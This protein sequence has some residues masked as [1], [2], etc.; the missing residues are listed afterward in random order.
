MCGKRNASN[1]H[2]TSP[3]TATSEDSPTG[4]AASEVEIV[5]AARDEVARRTRVAKRIVV[6]D[7]RG[8]KG[9]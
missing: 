3:L 4:W 9:V 2:S 8:V 5:A 7:R 1:T 6:K